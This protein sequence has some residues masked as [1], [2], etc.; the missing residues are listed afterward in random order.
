M[1]VGGEL[2]QLDVKWFHFYPG[3]NEL[4]WSVI[5]KQLARRTSNIC[6]VVDKQT[7]IKSES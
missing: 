4:S 1:L 5:L 3:E 7:I 2:H 6:E